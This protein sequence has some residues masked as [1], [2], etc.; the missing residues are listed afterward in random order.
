MRQKSLQK[1]PSM[2]INSK[3]FPANLFE[4]YQFPD[5]H[6]LTIYISKK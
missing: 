6:Y 4:L 1:L 2:K 3:Q 5:V